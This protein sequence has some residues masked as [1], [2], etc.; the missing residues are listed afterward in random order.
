M[1]R[2]LLLILVAALG[3]SG[4]WFIGALGVEKNTLRWFESRQKA[5]WI[6]S[7]SDFKLRGFPNRFDLSF[8]NLNLADPATGWAWTTNF[9]HLFTMSYKPDHIIAVWAPEQRLATPIT[10]LQ[11]SNSDMRASLVVQSLTTLALERT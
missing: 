7:Y 10:K 3:W 1:R 2:L 4:Y 8:N 6:A 9:F 5:G 11:L